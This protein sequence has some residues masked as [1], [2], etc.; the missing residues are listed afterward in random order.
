M[1]ALSGGAGAMAVGVIGLGR[2]GGPMAQRVLAAGHRVQV[3][4]IRAA[5]REAL[6]AAGAT[7][8]RDPSE[9]AAAADVVI[10]SLPGPEEVEHVMRRP[11]GVLAAVRPNTV[12]VETSTI[13][14]AQ[15]QAL[16][17]DLAARGACYLDA[18]VSG[19]VEGAVSGT[20][21]VM[22]GGNA[23]ALER[24]KPV[25]E[26]FGKP[27]FHLGPV[28]AGNSMKLVI[29]AVFL[30]QVAAF[31][32]AVALGQDSGI[33]LP[34]ILEVIAASSAHQPTIGKR[35]EKMIAADLTPR[36][37]VRAALK[38]LSLAQ[39]WCRQIGGRTDIMNSVVSAYGRAVEAG[40]SEKD[41]IALGNVFR[42]TDA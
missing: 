10:T 7:V 38:D 17:A 27:I 24:V 4:D 30:S 5:A 16:A 36:F 26:C 14:P 3:Y 35:Y 20:L 34:R 37:E 11:D 25:L 8:C 41:L 40:L 1:T 12:V 42:R 19:G 21:A 33:A 6:A 18:P 13:G 15:S 22:V 28:G 2:M 39:D 23:A 9:L 31:L 29:Q 32:E